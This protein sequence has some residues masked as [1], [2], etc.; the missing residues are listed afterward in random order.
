MAWVKLRLYCYAG[1][2]AFNVSKTLN[3][4][5]LNIS[6]ENVDHDLRPTPVGRNWL[7]IIFLKIKLIL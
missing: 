4:I 2:K 3:Q 6:F 5:F 7:N 1:V